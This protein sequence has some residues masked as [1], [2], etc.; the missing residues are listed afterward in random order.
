MSSQFLPVFIILLLVISPLAM[1]PLSACDNSGC[2]SFCSLNIFLLVLGACSCITFSGWTLLVHLQL[3]Q[4]NLQL[5]SGSILLLPAVSMYMR[6]KL[7]HSK[8]D[9]PSATTEM[10]TW[11]SSVLLHALAASALSALMLFN[12]RLNNGLTEGVLAL[13]CAVFISMLI[14]QYHDRF[15]RRKEYG[16]VVASLQKFLGLV[17]VVIAVQHQLSS[18]SAHSKNP[19]VVLNRNA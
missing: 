16:V 15:S 7:F 12:A 11:N 17:L 1:M 9:V 6:S 19:P 5:I 3:Q 10:N 4:S 14:A 2:G 8:K 13:F 18:L